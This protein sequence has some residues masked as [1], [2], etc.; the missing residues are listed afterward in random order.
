MFSGC[1]RAPRCQ[2]GRPRDGRERGGRQQPLPGLVPRYSVLE[3]VTWVRSSRQGRVSLAGRDVAGK[4]WGCERGWEQWALR[5]PPGRGAVVGGLP[6][7]ELWTSCQMETG[8]KEGVGLFSL[9]CV[10]FSSGSTRCAASAA[11]Q[12]DLVAEIAAGRQE[13]AP[14][15]LAFF[16][17]L[18][19][20]RLAALA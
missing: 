13:R 7:T 2:D 14:V 17:V 11:G 4:P 6:N 1:F 18:S 20:D 5:E 12:T 8:R 10:C 19:A 15:S 3:A 9:T 16:V